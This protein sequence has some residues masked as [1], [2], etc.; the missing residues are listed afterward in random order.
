METK[1]GNLYFNTGALS[2]NL[3]FGPLKACF[4]GLGILTHSFSLPFSWVLLKSFKNL[5]KDVFKCEKMVKVT[6]GC[7]RM[8]MTEMLQELWSIKMMAMKYKLGLLVERM[9]KTQLCLPMEFG[10]MMEAPAKKDWWLMKKR[11]CDAVGEDGPVTAEVTPGSAVFVWQYQIGLGDQTVVFT[12]EMMTTTT[13]DPPTECP[14]P[15]A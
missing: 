12:G 2:V 4:G 15:A 8:E 10:G 3:N 7:K 5:S 1:H 11:W 14:F 13:C 6:V 9:F